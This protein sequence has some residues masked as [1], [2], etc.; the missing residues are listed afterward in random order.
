[1]DSLVNDISYS[2]NAASVR[3]LLVKH[4][5][6]LI[7][8]NANTALVKD[9]FT[10]T[11]PLSVQLKI[12]D[13]DLMDLQSIASLHYRVSGIVTAQEAITK[14]RNDLHKNGDIRA[15]NSE[16]YRQPYRALQTH[17]NVQGQQL[18]LTNLLFDLNGAMI[19]GGAEY[20]L[21]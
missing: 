5:R 18:Q 9:A 11:S 16:V 19:D 2:A 4:G 21:Q 1:W 17:F 6:A 8:A 7:N 14:T 12:T 10:D 13:A 20:N 3:N 15:R